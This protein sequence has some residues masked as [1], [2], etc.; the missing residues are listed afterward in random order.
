MVDEGPS[1]ESHPLP[2]RGNG[3]TVLLVVVLAIVSLDFWRAGQEEEA[4]ARKIEDI[5]H[6][7]NRD[8]ELALRTLALEQGMHWE[9]LKVRLV[10]L[11]GGNLNSH[12][13]ELETLG[14]KPP[15]KAYLP[16]EG[17][18]F[19]HVKGVLEHDGV[20]YDRTFEVERTELLVRGI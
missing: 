10:R 19:L 11:S 6:A 18:M 3:L 20:L 16:V 15:R 14:I 9:E 17:D 7:H 13:R 4:V 2:S 5:A 8:P 12:Y 1:R